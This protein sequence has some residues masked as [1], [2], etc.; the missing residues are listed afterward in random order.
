MISSEIVKTVIYY[1]CTL[2]WAIIAFLIR[3]LHSRGKLFKNQAILAFQGEFEIKLL[4][5]N[6]LEH[7]LKSII[8]KVKFNEQSSIHENFAPQKT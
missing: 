3:V 8:L 1:I 6:K 4:W 2:S 7:L 5:I